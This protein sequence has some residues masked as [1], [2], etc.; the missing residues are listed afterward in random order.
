MPKPDYA[1]LSL[2]YVHKKFKDS[3][4]APQKLKIQK[5]AETVGL[6]FFNEEENSKLEKPLKTQSKP[7]K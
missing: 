2:G 6:G 3:E 1:T 7:E 5:V 4:E